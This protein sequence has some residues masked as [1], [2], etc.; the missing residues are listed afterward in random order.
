[1]APVTFELPNPQLAPGYRDALVQLMDFRVDDIADGWVAVEPS[2]G[3]RVTRSY[4]TATRICDA[5]S[6]L[7]EATTWQPMLDNPP[8]PDRDVGRRERLLREAERLAQLGTP[9]G[10]LQ[11]LAAGIA[12]ANTDAHEFLAPQL[13]TVF[14]EFPN[15]SLW[16]VS[17]DNVLLSRLTFLH[18]R[19]A[20]ELTP[21]RPIGPEQM[22]VHALDGHSITSGVMFEKVINPALLA[23]SPGAV[24]YSFAWSPHAL[25]LLYGQSVELREE[26]PRSLAGLYQPDVMAD[27]HANLWADDDFW[28][29][30]D[31]DDAEALFTWWVER[32]NDVYSHAA[33]PTAFEEGG[34]HRAEEQLAWLLT[35][36]RLVADGLL[37]LSGPQ[38][39]QMARLETAFDLLDKAESLLGYGVE[40]T[41]K[42]FER[43][44]RRSETEPRL[45]RAWET[46]PE[47]LRPRFQR[48]TTTVY[49]RIYEHV[50][51]HSL[52]FRRAA[53]SKV[54]VFNERADALIAMGMNDY[55]PKL[56]RA[57]RNS[58]HGFLD[59]LTGKQRFLVAT[60][61]GELPPEVSDLATLVLLALFADVH[62]VTDGTWFQ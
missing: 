25:V 15:G 32:L 42:G 39:P 28:L 34:R 40:D 41:G 21:D 45:N 10:T 36:E 54:Q 14:Q 19:I 38:D 62:R 16:L 59:Q 6:D 5:R 58:A 30:V 51:G 11:A 43:L 23:F 47:R 37:L 1:M 9:Q 7:D 46:L 56:V 18:S 4:F 29:D 27:V 12:G 8:W 53:N 49:D 2:E 20:L 33:D 24:G 35:I 55:V 60:H 31:E 26:Q 3:S 44:L 17:V 52:G 22:G 13:A 57:A 48:H 50:F 61:T